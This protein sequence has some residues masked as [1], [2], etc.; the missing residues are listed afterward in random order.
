MGAYGYRSVTRFMGVFEKDERRELET[1]PSGNSDFR[2]RNQRDPL[3]PFTLYICLHILVIM[4]VLVVLFG[5]L[6][7]FCFCIG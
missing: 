7:V 2:K 3:F 1:P 6:F 4:L 5:V